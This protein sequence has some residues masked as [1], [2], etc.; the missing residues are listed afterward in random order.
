M[1]NVAGML[2][3]EHNLKIV[4]LK[5]ERQVAPHGGSILFNME[6]LVTPAVAPRSTPSTVCFHSDFLRAKLEALGE[7]LNC[8]ITLTFD[9]N[10]GS[11]VEHCRTS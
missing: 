11:R 3:H 10:T 7:D 1:D 4:K 6:G 8:D 2:E 5:E 9:N